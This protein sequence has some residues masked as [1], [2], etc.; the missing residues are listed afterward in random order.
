MQLSHWELL[1]T[2]K[3]VRGELVEPRSSQQ[4]QQLTK[5][6]FESQGERRVF[7]ETAIKY[8]E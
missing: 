1:K 4:N 8:D 3:S 7:I 5:T 2:L 6:P